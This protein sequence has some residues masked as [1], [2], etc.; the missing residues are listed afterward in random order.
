MALGGEPVG[1]RFIEWNFVSSSR[2]TNRTG[3]GRLARRPHETAR[4]RQPGIHPARMNCRLLI[5]LAGRR[6]L[7]GCAVAPAG[8][9]HRS[10][11]VR[12]VPYTPDSG[13]LAIRCG[14]LIDGVATLAHIDALVVI[15]DG[16]IKSVK[17]D[18]SR[19]DAAAAHVPVLDLSATT[20][21]CPASST[22]T[23]IS[24]TGPRTPRI[25]AVYFTRPLEE[26]LR[27]SHENAAATLLAGFTTRAQRRHLC[28]RHRYC[29]C[30]TPS[31]AASA[32]GPAHAGERPVPHHS[33]RRRRPVRAGLPGARGQRAFSR[34]RGARRASNSASAPKSCSTSG[35][36]LLKVIASGA[37]LAFGG[38]PGAPEMTREE[39]DAVV[40][41]RARRRQESGRACAR[42]R[43]HSHGHRR[44]RRHHRT[45]LVSRR[46][47]HRRR[48]E[49]RQRG[50]RHGRVQ[51]RLHRHRGPRGRTGPRNSCARTSRPP[52]SSARRSPRR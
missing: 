35:S 25:C 43:I 20:P 14:L 38:V 40:E 47:R 41:S 13:T 27:Q 16:R 10:I 11:A 28:R 5:L 17:A 30:A 22:C 26:T 24:P 2:G 46:C 8:G 50:A 33:A 21:A 1:E 23:R 48:A 52:R 37:V 29:C 18:A 44:R 15:R 19:G 49:A 4:L 31:T 51:R 32:V 45:R 34:R 9:A 7:G 6:Q 42:R 39:I 12:Q 3:Q 36:D